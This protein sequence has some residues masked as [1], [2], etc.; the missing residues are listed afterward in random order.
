[1]T[2]CVEVKELVIVSGRVE[3]S[4]CPGCDKP[5]WTQMESQWLLMIAESWTVF[6]RS[7]CIDYYRDI[8]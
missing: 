7:Y 8:H 2:G 3:A 5:C 6:A 4:E 1:M